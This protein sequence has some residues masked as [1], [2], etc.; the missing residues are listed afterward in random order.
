MCYNDMERLCSVGGLHSGVYPIAGLEH[1]T[2]LLDWTTGLMY[3]CAVPK[4][5]VCTVRL[6]IAQ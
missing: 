1:W 6:I 3:A 5:S 4:I 2:G